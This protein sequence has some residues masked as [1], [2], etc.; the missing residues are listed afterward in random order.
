MHL[1]RGVVRHVAA[2][3]ALWLRLRIH[4]RPGVRPRV[5]DECALVRVLAAED[6]DDA[7]IAVPAG[8][9]QWGD[10][11]GGGGA[12]VAPGV[13][14]KVIAPGRGVAQIILAEPVPAVR[15]REGREP[16]ETSA[17]GIED[18]LLSATD[19]NGRGIRLLEGPF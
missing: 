3:A 17:V 13:R 5:I 4:P 16:Y 18:V 10:T 1:V 14:R 6:Y 8:A 7:M 15:P 12:Q 2:A 9:P 11:R 19:A